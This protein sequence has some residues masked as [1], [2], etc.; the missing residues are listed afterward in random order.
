LNKTQAIVSALF[1]TAT[2][3]ALI[4]QLDHSIAA[5]L[6]AFSTVLAII[7]LHVGSAE[8]AREHHELAGR[9]VSIEQK[10]AHGRSLTDAEA[11]KLICERLEIH[12]D[13][14]PIKRNLDTICHNELLRSIGGRNAQMWRVGPIQ[15]MLADFIDWR[16]HATRPP[17]S[18]EE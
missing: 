4:A 12:K 2:V 16:P 10:L 11:E 9:F 15:R 8:R 1:G 13:E 14:P 5:G 17:K 7:N 3:A 18:H 6:A